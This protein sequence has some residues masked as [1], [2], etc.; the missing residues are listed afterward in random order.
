MP[1]SAKIFLMVSEMPSFFE[2]TPGR[3][4]SDCILCTACDVCTTQIGL[5]MIVVAEPKSSTCESP[6]DWGQFYMTL[7]SDDA[8]KHRLQG[9]EPLAAS[10]RIKYKASR[11]LIEVVIHPK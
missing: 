8:S 5:L 9:A 10:P 2:E 7:T 3:A 11:S 1:S 4:E 6:R